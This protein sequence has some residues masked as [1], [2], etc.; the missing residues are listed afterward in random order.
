MDLNTRQLLG[1]IKLLMRPDMAP[2]ACQVLRQYIENNHDISLSFMIHPRQNY[3]TGYHRVVRNEDSLKRAL[4]HPI[5]EAMR[6]IEKTNTLWSAPNSVC[7]RFSGGVPSVPLLTVL[8]RSLPV[9]GGQLPESVFGDV[10]Q[11]GVVVGEVV[12]GPMDR[13]REVAAINLRSWFGFGVEKEER[14]WK[15][16]FFVLPSFFECALVVD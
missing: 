12:D 14:L 13:I 6:D 15:D 11:L 9:L 5:T 3:N 1:T 4:K 2:K 8:N 7:F 16:P 10:S